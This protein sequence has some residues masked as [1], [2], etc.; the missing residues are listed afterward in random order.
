M[1]EG[2][3]SPRHEVEPFGPK[4]SRSRSSGPEGLVVRAVDLVSRCS[5]RRPRSSSCRRGT[6]GELS[7]RNE[8]RA[9]AEARGRALRAEGLA[10]S[11]L[12]PGGPRFSGRRPRPS[13]F[14][15]EASILELRRGTRVELRRGT[16][17]EGRASPRGEGRATPRIEGRATP[18]GSQ[19][20]RSRG[21]PWA[22]CLC[23][24]GLHRRRLAPRSPARVWSQ[25]AP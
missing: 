14:G 17:N 1:N 5:G 9:V 13:L 20:S 3:A 7:P 23:R 8:G 21:A 16:R 19:P 4:A 24:R 22:G 15:P 11:F 10:E 25:G 2:R 18:S 6:R 12:G